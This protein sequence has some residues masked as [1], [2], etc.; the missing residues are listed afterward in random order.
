MIDLS[1][2]LNR[3]SFVSVDVETTG[4]HPRRDV[5]V[6]IAAVRV[7]DGKIREQFSTLVCIDRTIPYEAQRVHGISN[8][9]LIGHPRISEAMSMFQEFAAD[10]TLVEHSWKSF[11]AGFL[12]AAMGRAWEGPYINTCT[13]SRKL[14]PF[15]RSHSLAECCKRHKIANDQAHRALSDA[16]AT[17]QLLLCLL[18]ACSLRYPR[19]QDLVPV[20]SIERVHSSHV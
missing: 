1:T 13:L 10:G 19:L 20:C 6:E 4:L 5:I 15:H 16:R 18:E 11:D 14:F 8:Q 3:A 7:L 17:A 2:P 12:E 9:M